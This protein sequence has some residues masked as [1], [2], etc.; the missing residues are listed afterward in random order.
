MNKAV[1]CSASRTRRLSS[2]DA[3]SPAIPVRLRA[4]TMMPMRNRPVGRSQVLIKPSA[5]A[6]RAEVASS[7][8]RRR[9]VCQDRRS[10]DFQKTNARP[11]TVN[12]NGIAITCGCRSPSKKLKNGNSVI[13]SALGE[14]RVARHH[15]QKLDFSLG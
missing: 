3:V 7:Q 6:N 13:V 8:G 15:H 12:T 5:P 14:M 1:S 9:H 2:G 4:S 10:G 11:A